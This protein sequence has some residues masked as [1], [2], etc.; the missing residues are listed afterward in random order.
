[1]SGSGFRVQ[2]SGFKVQ[3]S[4]FRVQG[5]GFRV[6]GL[7]RSPPEAPPLVTRQSR[8]ECPVPRHPKQI[9]LLR[10]AASRMQGLGFRDAGFRVQGS[11]FRVQGLGSEGG[12]SGFR[13][14]GLGSGV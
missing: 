1:V 14:W 5:S 12:C 4:R 3:G 9:S 6:Q 7:P 2:G 10:E 13:V 11:G 8:S